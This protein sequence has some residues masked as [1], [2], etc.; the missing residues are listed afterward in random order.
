MMGFEYFEETEELQFNEINF[1]MLFV[2][3]A[4]RWRSDGEEIKNLDL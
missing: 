1:Y 4:Y 2:G 3:V